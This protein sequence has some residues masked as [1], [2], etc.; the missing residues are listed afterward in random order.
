MVR[1]A[2]YLQS[3]LR[4][5]AAAVFIPHGAQKL[6][7]FP[8]AI[9]G[10]HIS[11]ASQLGVASI[12][13]LGGGALMLIGL[14]SRPVAFVLAGE[15]AVAYFLAHAPRGRW[16]ILNGGELAILFC[17]IWL[18]FAAAGPGPLSLDA[19]WRRKHT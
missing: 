11:I 7:A 9:P 18:F 6:L 16:P 15:M 3:V 13:E 2:P 12:L 14:F 19:M 5:V 10:L 4:I 17:F 1:L 8:A